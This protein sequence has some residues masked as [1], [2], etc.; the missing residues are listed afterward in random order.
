MM[1]STP[2][3]FELRIVTFGAWR[4]DGDIDV[5]LVRPSD[6]HPPHSSRTTGIRKSIQ[7]PTLAI[8]D[9]KQR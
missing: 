3:V 7:P 2:N 8:A 1:T 4:Y 6:V 9:S 5:D